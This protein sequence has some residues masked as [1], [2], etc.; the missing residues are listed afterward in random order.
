MSE[1]IQ[2][3]EET[4][5]TRVLVGVPLHCS[6]MSAGTATSVVQAAGS[7]IEVGFQVMGLSLLAKNFNHLF[8][9]A[10]RGE[11]DYFLLLH[12]DIVIKP[13]SHFNGSWLELMV[14]RMEELQAAAISAVSP[15]K[16]PAGHTSTALE[17][18]RDN[19]YDMRRLTIREMLGLEYDYINRDDMCELFGV[20]KDEAGAFLINTACLMMD[21]KRFDW[22]KWNGF[23]IDDHIEWSKDK[24]PMCFTIPEDWKL[25]RFMH[26]QGWP[27]Y[28]T[29]E[30][31]LQ[32][33]GTH[34]Y[35]NHQP[36]GLEE[37]TVC[38]QVSPEKWRSS[39][40]TDPDVQ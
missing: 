39:Y 23:G 14:K 5:D 33:Q 26:E 21:L 36:W 17:L 8:Q 2:K 27:Y 13:P 35:N 24:Q 37:D 40:S 6:D 32:H 7:E 11:Y 18:H 16:S 34:G 10:W 15:I 28:A 30:I 12:A 25:S 29:R 4:N 20:D 9:A 19:P 38:G 1:E 31:Q 3:Q 22:T